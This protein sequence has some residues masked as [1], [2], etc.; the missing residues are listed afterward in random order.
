MRRT[1]LATVLLF[2]SACGV[3]ARPATGPDGSPSWYEI[4]CG[5][6]HHAC[7]EKARELCP[8]GYEIANRDNGTD[9]IVS[10]AIAG[11]PESGQMLARCR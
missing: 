3:S 10:D 6:D 11:D 4:T 1:A 9:R 7:V 2:T 8:N 5:G